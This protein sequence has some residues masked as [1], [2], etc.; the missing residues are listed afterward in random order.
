MTAIST[1]TLLDEV[2]CYACL[3]ISMRDL[4]KISLLN[5]IHNP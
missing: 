3:G 1:Q 4:I 2:K 5:R